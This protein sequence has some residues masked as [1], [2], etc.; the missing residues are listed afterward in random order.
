VIDPIQQALEEDAGVS[1]V[2]HDTP[3][4]RAT[5]N[6]QSIDELDRQLLVIRERRLQRVRELEAIAKVKADEAQL[7]TFMKFERAI[8][9]ARKALD[10]LK[11]QE[12]KTEAVL[13]A[14]R[15]LAIECNL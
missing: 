8:T 9:R 11:E 3:I 6:Q 1:I 14:A 13:R 15:L 7:I 4:R 5:I 12:E 10:K 2:S